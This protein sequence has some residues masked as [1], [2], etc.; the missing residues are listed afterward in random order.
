MEITDL[1]PDESNHLPYY[2]FYYEDSLS[3]QS[4]DHIHTYSHPVAAQY[5]HCLT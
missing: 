5:N 2:D 4:L 1:Q 3:Q